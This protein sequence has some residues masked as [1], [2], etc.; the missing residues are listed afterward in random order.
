[1]TVDEVKKLKLM[2]VDLETFKNEVAFSYG[3]ITEKQEEIIKKQDDLIDYM[4]NLLST[5]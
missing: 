4:L 3:N 2:V 1:M 5:K